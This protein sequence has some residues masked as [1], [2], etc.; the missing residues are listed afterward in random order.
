MAHTRESKAL[1]INTL[2]EHLMLTERSMQDWLSKQEQRLADYHENIGIMKVC[3]EAAKIS[4]KHEQL[5]LI[6]ACQNYW[7]SLHHKDLLIEEAY[8]FIL[9]ELKEN[10]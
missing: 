7:E 2:E 6:H 3:E 1:T 4:N 10:Q 8:Q 5:E 9:K